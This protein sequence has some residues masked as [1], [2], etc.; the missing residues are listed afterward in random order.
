MQPPVDALQEF[1]VQTRT[2]S[3]EFG[4][5]AGAVI[6]ASV[7][8]GTNKFSG[9]LFGFMRDEALNANTWDNN[10]AGREKG[11]FNQLI[12]GGTFGGPIIT[13]KTFFFGD[14]QSARTEALSQGDGAAGADAP[15][16]PSER[17]GNMVGQ[18]LRAAGC[19]DAVNKVISRRASIGGGTV[20]RP[21]PE[22]KRAGAES[23]TTSSSPTASS[24]TTRSV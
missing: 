6:N 16:R 22:P 13:G 18:R 17:T 10:R 24:T 4:K 7:K 1:K 3:S 12:A 23:S 11:P 14:Y 2:Y 9:S 8:Q 20:D 5:A 21:V 19:V 15:R